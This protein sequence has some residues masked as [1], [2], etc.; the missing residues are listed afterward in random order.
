MLKTYFEW[1]AEKLDGNG[2]RN[3]A[4]NGWKMG[5]LSRYSHPDGMRC[6]AEQEMGTLKGDN[7][8]FPFKLIL[9]LCTTGCQ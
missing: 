2:R 7:V 9:I 8:K 6:D 5:K 3:L 4:T 1:E